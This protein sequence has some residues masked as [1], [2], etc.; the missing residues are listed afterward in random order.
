VLKS[1]DR[2]G[3]YATF[4]TPNDIC[5]W[6]AETLFTKEPCTIDWIESFK[7][8]EVFWD[9][10][11]NVGG[12]SVWAA[13]H[14]AKVIAFEPESSNYA[15]LCR[16]FALNETGLAYC[17]ALTDSNAAR[18][19]RMINPSVLYLTKM[20]PGGSCH[21]FDKQ[22]GFDLQPRPG[23]PQGA[24][25]SSVDVLVSLGF[26]APDHIKIDV[27][28]FEH[29][30]IDGALV[31]LANGVKS[32]QIEV[33]ENLPE[34]Q[35]MVRLLLNLGY[36]FNPKQVD[37]A[38]RKDGAFKG[39]AEYQF[40][41]ADPVE[42]YI[43]DKIA[44][45]PVTLYPFPHVHIEDV[46]PPEFLAAVTPQ[47]D[48]GYRSL[49]EARGT[50]GYPERYVK[51]APECARWMLDGRLKALLDEKFG[52]ESVK[53][54]LLMLRDLPGYQIGPHTDTPAKVVTALFYV[55]KDWTPAE[56]GTSVY[57]P[58]V[59][60]FRDE[61]GIHHKRDG[62]HQVWTAPG[63]PGSVFIFAR[64]NNSF[65]GCEPYAGTGTRD[66]LLYDTRR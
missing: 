5:K 53:D 49:K 56:H 1:V 45:A 10:G 4:S 60:E 3:T 36:R 40:R 31:T 44:D 62:F 19:G 17:L 18:Q 65:H 14:G 16:N 11:A 41:R 22:V 52:V 38:R 32:L 57:A 26:A 34:H 47:S 20:E 15:V 24:I 27:D 63:K 29:K 43:L 59:K 30:V 8:G 48:E 50:G 25:G 2:N 7:P 6:R 23:I 33:N 55:T 61:K 64:A 46:L 51:D 9:I 12:Y 39:C 58:R 28:G 37:A 54:E 13:K 35:A 42:E 21:S 66:I